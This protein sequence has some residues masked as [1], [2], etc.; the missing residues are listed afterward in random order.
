MRQLVPWLTLPT[1]ILA[2]CDP[3][4]ETPCER[5]AEVTGSATVGTGATAWED[6]TDGDVVEFVRGPQGGLHVYGSLAV[7]G[8]VQGKTDELS[9][10]DNPAVTY[11]VV[12]A[13]TVVGGYQG[14]PRHF[15][16]ESDGSMA[17]VGDL[18]VLYTQDPADMEGVT[19]DLR[20]EVEDT[21]GRTVSDTRSVSLTLGGEK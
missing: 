18:L 4:P 5:A 10:P 2:G 6:V 19:V 1:L 17:F 21:C 13:G 3:E 15:T 7:T 11:E 9:D 8:I 14:L 12:E 16:E 20:A